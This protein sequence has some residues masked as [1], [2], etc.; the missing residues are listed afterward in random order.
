[1]AEKLIDQLDSNPDS[2]IVTLKQLYAM[3]A[4][5]EDGRIGVTVKLGQ[6]DEH[7]DEPFLVLGWGW[8]EEEDEDEDEDFYQREP[9][10][11]EEDDYYEEDDEED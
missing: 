4:S 10:W 11:D 8:P 6:A 9:Y 3:V 7:P 5:D 2:V 1:M